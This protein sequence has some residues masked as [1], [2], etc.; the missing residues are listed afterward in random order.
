M[1]VIV[2]T[3]QVISA[4]RA[5]NSDNGQASISLAGS[6]NFLCAGAGKESRMHQCEEACLRAEIVPQA[7]TSEDRHVAL[8]PARDLGPASRWLCLQLRTGPG[9]VKAR[10][11]CFPGTNCS[12]ARGRR[13]RKTRSGSR[14]EGTGQ[15]SALLAMCSHVV[16]R[17]YLETLRQRLVIAWKAA[18]RTKK[19]SMCADD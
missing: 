13:H 17:N 1:Y 14:D 11:H 6:A 8:A 15:W 16:S 12:G 5:V 2:S 7:R 9:L 4:A 10:E 18:R 3:G 19:P